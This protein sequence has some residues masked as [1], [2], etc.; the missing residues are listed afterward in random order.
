MDFNFILTQLI[1]GFTLATLLFLVASGLTLIFGVGNI[2]NF[3]HGSFYMIGAYFGYQLVAVWKVNFWIALAAAG[4][5]AGLVGAAAEFLFLRR[6]YGR[7]QEGGFQILLTYCLILIFDDLVKLIWGT[8]YKS[9]SKPSGFEGALNVGDIPIPTYNFAIIVIGLV[10]VLAAWWL[11]SRTRPGRIARASAVDR[12]MLGSLG[13]NVP[14]TLTVVFGLATA[15]GGMTGALAAPLRS[16]TPGAGIEVIIDSLIVVVL[17]GMGNF[18]G[19]WLGAVLLGEV[20]AFAVAYVP[21]WATL[22]SYLVMVVTLIFKPEGLFAPSRL[23][24]V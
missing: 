20:N 13:V 18:W 1:S 6:I 10:V 8:E 17:G 5:G 11:L 16:V 21:E 23:R 7:A 3:A 2:F 22:F 9:V 14:L 12:E 4:V 15:L 19:A 24:K